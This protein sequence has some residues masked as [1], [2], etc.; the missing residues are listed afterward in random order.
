MDNVLQ[1]YRDRL[2]QHRY[3]Q[4]TLNIY[5]N[6]FR[7]YCTYFK[8]KQLEEIRSEQIN[9]YI[10]Y[11]IKTNNISISQQNQRINSIK[12]YYEKILGKEKQYYDLH[13]PKKEHRLPKILSKHEVQRIL[14]AC[15]NIK[16]HCIILLMYSA[17]LRRSELIDLK[18]TDIDSERM[19]VNI[20]GA[21]GKKDRVTL[22]SE[23]T[24]KCCANII[25]NTFQKVS[26]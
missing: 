1:L 15:N 14:R 17:G 2:I 16:H 23:N 26:F 7:D 3:S 24:L 4:N 18:I 19:V 9:A 10:L 21:K 5:C 8:N 12:F 13:R 25:K 22:L 20:L 11:L 6:Y